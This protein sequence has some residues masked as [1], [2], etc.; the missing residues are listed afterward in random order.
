LPDIFIGKVLE[1]HHGKA[2][3]LIYPE[4]AGGLRGLEEFSHC[5]IIYMFHKAIVNIEELMDS[6]ESVSPMA[7]PRHIRFGIFA[8]RSPRR[9]SYLG[10]SI[11]R[12]IG[13]EN[14]ILIVDGLDAYPDSPIV[15]IKPY[16]P[17]DV[18]YGAKYPQW[19]SKEDSARK[20]EF[21]HMFLNK[22]WMVAFEINKM[23][24]EKGFEVSKVGVSFGNY[25]N[26]G[27]KF[28]VQKYPLPFFVVEGIC[29]ILIQ[30]DKIYLTIPLY[31]ETI[32]K[33][34]IGDIVNMCPN[35]AE[36]YGGE[37]FLETYYPI[38]NATIN[39]IYEKI[40]NSGEKTIQISIRIDHE[41]YND[42]VN[43]YIAIKQIIEKHGAKT[44]KY[45]YV[46]RTRS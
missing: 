32:T 25:I 21:V 7:A 3:I 15:D 27:D 19:L 16:V 6:I 30:I 11:V 36:I 1:N 38:K 34:L 45:G 18:V 17:S 31:T 22:L 23:F 5:I 2:K 29:E 14:N 26:I 46:I 10:L 20:I 4:F 33:E 39:G 42:T 35:D 43:K 24:V 9:P 40:K 13:I 8:T 41:K 28:V 44:V 12:I 37:T